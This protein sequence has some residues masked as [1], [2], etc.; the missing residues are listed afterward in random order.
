MSQFGGAA[1]YRLYN[2][3]SSV[4]IPKNLMT[5]RLMS[6]RYVDALLQHTE[7]TFVIAGLWALTG[8][9]Q[10]AH[11]LR[12]ERKKTSTYGLIRCIKLTVNSVTAFSAAPLFAGF[13][14][15]V[16]LVVA[17]SLVAAYLILSSLFFRE[18][19]GGLAIDH[20]FDLVSRRIDVVLPGSFGNLP[21]PHIS[22]GEAPTGHAGSTSLRSGRSCRCP[23]DCLMA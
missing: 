23:P 20:G 10:V 1:Y 6:R 14:L 13:Y 2:V 16:G 18:D 9:Q 17:S 5:I 7:S 11:P 8:F 3:V 21:G 22:G 12:K 4:P 15:G 19:A